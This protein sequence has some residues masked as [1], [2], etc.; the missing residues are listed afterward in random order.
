MSQPEERNK[1]I[2]ARFDGLTSSEQD[3]LSAT[4][5]KAKKE[6]APKSRGTIIEGD[7]NALEGRSQESLQPED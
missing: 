5:K 6:I 7:M 2:N 4:I 3:R 1:S